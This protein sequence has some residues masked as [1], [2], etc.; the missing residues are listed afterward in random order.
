[1]RPSAVRGSPLAIRRLDQRGG[2]ALDGT[3]H[4][5]DGRGGDREQPALAADTQ[6]SRLGEDE[7]ERGM[8]DLAVR[9]GRIRRRADA[10]ARR[11]HRECRVAEVDAGAT[12]EHHRFRAERGERR[13]EPRTREQEVV[14][15]SLRGMV[16]DLEPEHVHLVGREVGRDGGEAPGA[17]GEP[18]PHELCAFGCA[19]PWKLDRR[20]AA[21]I[22]ARQAPVRQRRQAGHRRCT[23]LRGGPGWCRGTRMG[24]TC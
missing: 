7:A 4:L 19:R 20:G 24:S 15:R 13:V 23:L 2:L 3:R 21:G 6:H 11:G 18:Q 12:A 10:L 14:D 5:R 8:N 16:D 9:L 17:I 22:L 1:M